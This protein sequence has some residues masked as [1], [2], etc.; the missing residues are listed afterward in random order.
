MIFLE[1]YAGDYL[2]HVQCRINTSNKYFAT[3]GKVKE[4]DS[5]DHVAVIWDETWRNKEGE[6]RH[7]YFWKNFKTL[8]GAFALAFKLSAGLADHTS[9]FTR[10]ELDLEHIK[11][12]VPFYDMH[13]WK[14]STCY[15]VRVEIVINE[16]EQK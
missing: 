14:V 1:D 10:K 12:A 4:G 13:E 11:D 15:A 8:N 6:E 5:I 3:Y 7:P 9:V 16:K 2:T